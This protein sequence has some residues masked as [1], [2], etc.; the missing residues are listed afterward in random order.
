MRTKLSVSEYGIQDTESGEVFT[1]TTEE[2]M[3]ERL[4]YP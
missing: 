3:Y 1:D 4:G 2:A